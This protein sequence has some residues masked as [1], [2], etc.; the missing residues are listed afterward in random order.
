MALHILR[1]PIDK[2]KD[3]TSDSRPTHSPE[4]L[5]PV[6]SKVEQCRNRSRRI[7]NEK[8][9]HEIEALL[10]H[11]SRGCLSIIA[12]SPDFPQL[13]VAYNTEKRGKPGRFSHVNDVRV[14]RRVERTFEGD[15]LPSSV[16]RVQWRLKR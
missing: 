9:L 2:G 14:E 13:F 8:T 11:N 4:E 3:C 1:D 6:C 5:R 16:T 12:S 10:I 7:L 15:G